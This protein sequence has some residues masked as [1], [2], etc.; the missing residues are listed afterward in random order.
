[1]DHHSIITQVSREEEQINC[2]LPEKVVKKPKSP[3]FIRQF[4][5]CLR[6]NTSAVQQQC[7]PLVQ[8]ATEENGSIH[9]AESFL[10]QPVRVQDKNKKC[11][12]IDLD[13][14]LVH[15]SFTP[16]SNPDFVI[17]VEIDGT[18]HQV[19][20]MKRPFVDEFLQK[21]G[22]L[23]ECVLFTASLGKYADPV[24]DLLDKWGVFRARLF[25]E[26]CVFHRGNYVKDLSRLGREL[27]KVVIVDNSPASYLF[28]PRNAVPVVSWFDD[29]S[30]RMLLD[31]IPF[32]EDLAKADDVYT[33]LCSENISPSMTM[34]IGAVP[35]PTTVI[36]PPMSS[37]SIPMSP[38]PIPMV[39]SVTCTT[40]H[41]TVV[42]IGN[43]SAGTAPAAAVANGNVVNVS[44]SS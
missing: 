20:V 8:S 23:F 14:T 18:I 26:S 39:S 27:N 7:P 37:P 44:A 9:K 22:E 40:L 4:F 41:P 17:P 29:M 11:V 43:G 30:D 42:Q 25:R 19:Y 31:L 15:S 12:V 36:A 5:C 33:F 21:M 28:H 32:F 35:T 13:E 6:P 3:S 16:V 34:Y 2:Q 1:M 38:S 24:T 10:L